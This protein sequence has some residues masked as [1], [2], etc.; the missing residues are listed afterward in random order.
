[1][2]D[3]HPVG[4]HDALCIDRLHEI[5][6]VKFD[7]A[8][9][10]ELY[11]CKDTKKVTDELRRTI[12]RILDSNNHPNVD[13]VVEKVKNRK[14]FR[15]FRKIFADFGIKKV[16]FQGYYFDKGSPF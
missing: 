12:R 14:V 9:I 8:Y 15:F 3:F 6:T 11:D 5:D 1:M 16:S 10:S 7:G 2:D 13:M 4:N